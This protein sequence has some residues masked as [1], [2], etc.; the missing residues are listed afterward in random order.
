M[1]ATSSR[2]R[3]PPVAVK[4]L[5]TCSKSVPK[6]RF[7]SEL[8]IH[9]NASKAQQDLEALQPPVLTDPAQA[10][11]VR[12]FDIFYDEHEISIVMEKAGKDLEWYLGETE[13]LPAEL[14]R[15]WAG[16]LLSALHFL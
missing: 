12:L 5:Y 6:S 8:V 7:L 10:L 2:S 1:V 3:M 16:E 14:V 13:V 11:V 4:Q 15:R 9:S